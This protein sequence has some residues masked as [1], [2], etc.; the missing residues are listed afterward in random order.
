[1]AADPGPGR[2]QTGAF[3]DQLDGLLRGP[4]VAHI[5]V[6]QIFGVPGKVHVGVDE[7][8]QSQAPGKIDG[9]AAGSQAIAQASIVGKRQHFSVT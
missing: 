3:G 8:R 5:H 6:I 1:M 7:S 4:G 2:D 9:L